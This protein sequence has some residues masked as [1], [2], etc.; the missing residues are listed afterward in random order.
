MHSFIGA[1]RSFLF[2]FN[3][4]GIMLSGTHNG[5]VFFWDS[6]NNCKYELNK[7][8]R[9]FRSRKSFGDSGLDKVNSLLL[10]PNGNFI[11]STRAGYIK[12]WDSE[13]CLSA[14]SYCSAIYCLLL[15]DD[16]NLLVLI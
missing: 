8:L 6:H 4:D 11:T 10:L 16:G 12:F 2:T 1:I 14:K 3:A 7:T 9:Q 5:T 13:N 15:L